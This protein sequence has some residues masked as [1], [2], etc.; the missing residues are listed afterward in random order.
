MTT[1]S[2]GGQDQFTLGRDPRPD[3]LRLLPL[4][5]RLFDA[6]SSALGDRG[7]P[8]TWGRRRERARPPRTGVGPFRVP[9]AWAAST[10]AHCP[11]STLAVT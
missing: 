8:M 5:G 10:A 7:H 6:A 4:A 9:A 1:I 3:E 2:V 11:G